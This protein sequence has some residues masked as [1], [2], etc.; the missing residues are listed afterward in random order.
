M[1]AYAGRSQSPLLPQQGAALKAD[2]DSLVRTRLAQIA[3][4]ETAPLQLNRHPKQIPHQ[5][6]GL[7]F[8]RPFYI[9]GLRAYIRSVP[10]AAGSSTRSKTRSKLIM[11]TLERT[12][13]GRT[14]NLPFGSFRLCYWRLRYHMLAGMSIPFLTK[15]LKTPKNTDVSAQLAPFSCLL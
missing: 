5:K 12:V 9:L 14:L 4:F 8:G 2:P 1:R 15:T 10:T 7:P 6:K 13:L 3:Y 11:T